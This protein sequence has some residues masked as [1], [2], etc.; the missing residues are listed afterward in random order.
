MKDTT[1]RL[2]MPWRKK[3]G[4]RIDQMIE[5]VNRLRSQFL[6]PDL[7]PAERERVAD[8]LALWRLRLAAFL[9]RGN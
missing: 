2:E 5:Q 7:S 9:A 3:R 4:D 1:A 8:L 6:D